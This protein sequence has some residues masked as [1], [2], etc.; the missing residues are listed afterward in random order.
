VKHLSDA[1]LLGRLLI[2]P[3]KQWTM[4]ERSANNKHS[5]LLFLA[6]GTKKI[7]FI[8]VAPGPNVIKLFTMVIYHHSMV[9][10][11]FCVIKQHYSGNYCGMAENYHGI[12]ITNVT[13]HNLT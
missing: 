2:L 8:A 5:S 12:C 9:I 3:A 7:N 11:S 6:S 10:L 4:V 1:P 13:K